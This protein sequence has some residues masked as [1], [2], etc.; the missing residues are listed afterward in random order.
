MGNSERDLR[1]N[2]P[3]AEVQQGLAI[4][5][6]LVDTARQNIQNWIDSLN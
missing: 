4:R 6:H 5:G 1:A 2:L 3:T